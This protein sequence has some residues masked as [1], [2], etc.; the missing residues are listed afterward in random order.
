MPAALP[1]MSFDDT[2]TERLRQACAALLPQWGRPTGAPVERLS[3]SENATFLVPAVAGCPA[4]VLRVY[5]NGYHDRAEIASE[6]AWID[7][8]RQTGTVDTPAPVLASA[9]HRLVDLPLDGATYAV[10]AFAYV[11]GAELSP[12]G[13]LA[14]AFEQLG[15]LTARLHLQARAWRRPEG[16]TRKHW[17]FAT[18]LGDSPHWGDWRAALGL[19]AQ[20][21]ALLQR[22]VQRVERLVGAYGTGPKVFGLIHADLRLANLLAEGDRLTVIDF[23]DCGF[24]WFVYDFAAAISF[25]ETD[26]AIPELLHRWLAGY[27]AVAPLDAADEAM[28][29]A[30]VMLRR[31][32]LTAWIASHPE[33]DA[34]RALGAGFTEGTLALA[35]RFLG[36]DCLFSN[37]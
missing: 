33:A 25:I 4:L 36:S 15:L 7:A 13:S 17:T 3:V 1:D 22:T 18:T 26:P 30:M 37:S 20:G 31:I 14:N 8:I 23:D 29:P 16:F 28:I 6:L 21:R 32:L 24:G 19:S 35:E 5:R 34:A 10:T 9:G 2:T 12:E 11:P 27:R